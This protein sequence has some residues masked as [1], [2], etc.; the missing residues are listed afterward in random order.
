MKDKVKMIMA[1]ILDVATNEIDD[2]FGPDSTDNWDSLRNLQLVTELEEQFGIS[3]TM[4][5][6]QTMINFNSIVKVVESHKS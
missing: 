3:L 2:E 4:S 6:I 1:E 5:E